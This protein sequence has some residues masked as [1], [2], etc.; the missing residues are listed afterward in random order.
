MRTGARPP[1]DPPSSPLRN[2]SRAGG[3]GRESGCTKGVKAWDFG[4]LVAVRD[5]SDL[6]VM[7]RKD[8]LSV[9]RPPKPGLLADYRLALMPRTSVVMVVDDVSDLVPSRAV[10]TPPT[11]P[12]STRHLTGCTQGV[13]VSFSERRSRRRGSSFCRPT[14]TSGHSARGTWRTP[15]ATCFSAVPSH[16]SRS[17]SSSVP[18]RGG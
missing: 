9:L 13:H 6:D 8:A 5:V 2:T 4:L 17:G 11:R 7:V 14:S 3:A 1:R 10:P 16:G 15:T 18:G 12:R